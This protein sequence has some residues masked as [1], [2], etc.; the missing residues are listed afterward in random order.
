MTCKQ[1]QCSHRNSENSKKR[2]DQ[3]RLQQRLNGCRLNATKSECQF[4]LTCSA[5][6]ICSM[7]NLNISSDLLGNIITLLLNYFCVLF[8]LKSLN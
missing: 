7:I 1:L 5:A 3:C 6:L 2:F 4:S 8:H